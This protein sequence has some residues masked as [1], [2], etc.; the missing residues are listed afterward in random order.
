[1]HVVYCIVA[2]LTLMQRSETQCSVM[3]CHV[4]YYNAMYVSIEE[5]QE[6]LLHA[7]PE[8]LQHD[9][10]GVNTSDSRDAR[11]LMPV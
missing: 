9:F 4:M 5:R 10:G 1:M 11:N 2:E 7:R 8:D 3:Y 6:L